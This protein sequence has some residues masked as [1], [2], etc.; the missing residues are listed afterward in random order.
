[1]IKSGGI[2]LF[3]KPIF[4]IFILLLSVYSYSQDISGTY[5]WSYDNGRNNF[6]IYLS[7][8]NAVRGST[9]TS[10]KGEHCGV[11]DDGQRMDCSYEEFSINLNKV[12][13]NVFTGTILSAYARTIHD[14]KV[15]YLP[16]TDQIHWEVTLQRSGQIYFPLNVI[17]DK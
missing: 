5:R 14:I 7:A 10:F 17:M 11:F 12:S 16:A 2:I 1:M 6:E 15:T 3:L 8:K 13:Q 9:P 4:L